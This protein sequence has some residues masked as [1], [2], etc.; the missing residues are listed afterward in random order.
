MF[1]FTIV[2]QDINA[3][4]LKLKPFVKEAV[5]LPENVLGQGAYGCVIELKV[6]GKLY[7]GKK[8]RADACPDPL[9]FWNKFYTEYQVLDKLCHKHIVQ[10]RGITVMSDQNSD[11]PIL[12]MEKLMTN[13]EKFITSPT[14]FGIHDPDFQLKLSFLTGIADGLKYLHKSGVIHRDLTA[15]NILLDDNLVAKISDFGNSA[16]VDIEPSSHLETKSKSCVPGTLLYM[17]PEACDTEHAYYS[18]KLDVFSFGHLSLFII[19]NEP[20][21]SLLPVAFRDKRAPGGLSARSEIDRRIKYMNLLYQKIGRDHL[22]VTMIIQ[23]LQNFPE[24]RPS[25]EDVFTALSQMH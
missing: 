7:A 4:R 6:G 5:L 24:D 13:L 17:P 16:I 22:L 20:P 18:E 21:S 23:C 2:Q 25:A 1:P 10:Y 19:T 8:L 3:Q 15:R 12:I 9:K 14:L 11:P